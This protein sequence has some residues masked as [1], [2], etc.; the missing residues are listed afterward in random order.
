MQFV[1]LAVEV[2]L[3]IVGTALVLAPVLLGASKLFGG[4]VSN[5]TRKPRRAAAACIGLVLIVAGLLIRR[6]III[7]PTNANTQPRIAAQPASAQAPGLAQLATVALYSCHAPADPPPPP[8]GAIASKDQM[9]ASNRET[10]KYNNDMNQYLDCLKMTSANLQAQYRGTASA[11]E[12]VDVDA[13]AVR[14]NNEAVD[15]LQL[16]VKAFNVELA[17]Y[18]ARTAP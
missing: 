5:A 17:K 3:F 7:P 16:K 1:W 15:R 4:E 8:D 6:A 2:G 18:K 14:L 9:I 10:S 13:L 12:V 11:S